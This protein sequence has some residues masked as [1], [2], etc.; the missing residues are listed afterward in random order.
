MAR[1]Q[2]PGGGAAWMLMGGV[3]CVSASAPL[4][5]LAAPLPPML[6][7]AGRIAVAAAVLAAIAGRSLGA[8]R[9]LPAAD[10]GRVV[11]AGVLLG[12]HFGTWISSLSYT[13]TAASMALLATQ[14]IFGAVLGRAFLG[15]RLRRGE[16]VAM[17]VAAAGTVVLA[18]GDADGGSGALVGD[19][20]ALAGAAT[21]AAYLTV[22]R[23]MRETLPLW[24]YL[25]A[26]NAV[27]ATC[28]AAAALVAWPG[29]DGAG[30]IDLTAV[31]IMAL[32]C[33]VGGHTLLNASVRRVTVH[34]VSLG[35]LAEPVLASLA[36]WAAFGEQPPLHA[37]VG[38]ALIV[39]GVYA[40]FRR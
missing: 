31:V 13:S 6:I 1:A 4:I 2:S 8:L 30:A 5:R 38:G 11:L 23:R 9:A 37:A 36:T 24:P 28:L 19:L 35:I 7:A 12:A 26:V 16:V 15:D 21:A 18:V 22:G 3:L 33:S 27:A 14:P 32:V 29:L 17:V 39:A 20:L 10:R 25:A 40:G 34:L